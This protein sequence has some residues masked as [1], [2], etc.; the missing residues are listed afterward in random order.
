VV[1]VHLAHEAL[2]DGPTLA[3][4]IASGALLV[5]LRINSAWLALGGGVVGLAIMAWR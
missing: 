4:A 2:I 5:V 3:L 1:T